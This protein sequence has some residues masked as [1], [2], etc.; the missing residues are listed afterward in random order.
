M[1]QAHSEQRQWP[2]SQWVSGQVWR[3]AYKISKMVGEALEREKSHKIERYKKDERQPGKRREKEEEEEKEK[4]RNKREKLKTRKL[5]RK[6]SDKTKR[7]GR[8]N[9]WQK[10]GACISRPSF[11]SLMTFPLFETL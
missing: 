10:Q 2:G 7:E 9:T 8:E 4:K 11:L 5:K 3:D 6:L 1:Q